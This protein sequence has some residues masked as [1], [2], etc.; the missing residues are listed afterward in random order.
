MQSSNVHGLVHRPAIDIDLR[1]IVAADF[2]G[3]FVALDVRVQVGDGIADRV[4]R[5]LLQKDIE[6]QVVVIRPALSPSQWLAAKNDL[7]SFAWVEAR[8]AGNQFRINGIH[9]CLAGREWDRSED[10]P[11]EDKSVIAR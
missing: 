1:L 10:E 2:K 5:A 4:L 9:S 7:L 6:V 11:V 8:F 3:Q